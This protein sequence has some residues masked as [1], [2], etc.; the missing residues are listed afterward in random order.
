MLKSDA[1]LRRDVNTVCIEED[2]AR[3]RSQREIGAKYMNVN[4]GYAPATFCKRVLAAITS[5]RLTYRDLEVVRDTKKPSP[6]LVR[7]LKGG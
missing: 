3:P 2:G 6:N 5:G 4:L 1:D 7:I